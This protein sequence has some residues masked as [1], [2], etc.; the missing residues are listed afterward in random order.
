MLGIGVTIS[1]PLNGATVEDHPISVRGTYRVRPRPGD[2]VVLFGRRKFTYYP[3]A[4]IVWGRNL[5]ERTWEC[6][7]V[8]LSAYEDNPTEYGL[9]VARVS[10][11]FSVWLRNYSK[12]ADETKKLYGQPSW[13]GAEMPTLPPGFEVLASVTVTRPAKKK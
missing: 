11:D 8:W 6:P 12:V 10:E 2:H 4:P 13:I 1:S 9:V 7:R 5:E 3:Q